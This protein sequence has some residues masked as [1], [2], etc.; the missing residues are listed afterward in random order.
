MLTYAVAKGSKHE[1]IKSSWPFNFDLDDTEDLSWFVEVAAE[2]YRDNK[3]GWEE[4]RDGT[5]DI[6]L[7]WN[8]QSLGIYEVFLE[9]APEYSVDKKKQ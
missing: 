4:W 7:F 9:Y 1:L 5:R 8:D 3:D 2:D 6:E